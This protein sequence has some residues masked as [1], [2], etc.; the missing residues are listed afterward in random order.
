MVAEQCIDVLFSQLT[1]NFIKP[2]LIAQFMNSLTGDLKTD[3]KMLHGVDIEQLMKE[4]LLYEVQ[5]EID[6]EILATAVHEHFM[7]EW[8]EKI[9][10][11]EKYGIEIDL[12]E[13]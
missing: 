2:D 3:I 12:K 9:L 10:Y 8:S 4:A 6:R 7:D 11:P 13:I 1:N 5:T